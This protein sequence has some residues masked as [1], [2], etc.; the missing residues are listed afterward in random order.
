[1]RPFRA[2]LELFVLEIIGLHSMFGYGALS[3][4]FLCGGILVGKFGSVIIVVLAVLLYSA[5]KLLT[6][7]IRIDFKLMKSK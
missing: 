3:G 7:F 4:L 5:F 6:V 1:L 2:R